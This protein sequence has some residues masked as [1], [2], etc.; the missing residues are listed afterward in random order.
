M[1]IQDIIINDVRNGS[2]YQCEIP[3]LPPDPNIEGNVTMLCVAGKCK[4]R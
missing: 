1:V 3:Q 2:L 4:H